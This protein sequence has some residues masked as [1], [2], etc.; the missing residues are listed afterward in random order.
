MALKTSEQIK[1][2]IATIG[3]ASAKLKANVQECAV[4]TIGHAR[5]H[6][7]YTLMQRLLD[8]LSGAVRKASLVA[9]FEKH[10]PVKWESKTEKLEF[11]KRVD[12][13]EWSEEVQEILMLSPW[14]EA[15][16]ETIKSIY[17]PVSMFESILKTSLAK[18]KKHEKINNEWAVIILE[19]AME[20][21]KEEERKQRIFRS[22]GDGL[23]VEEKGEEDGTQ[24]IEEP[25]LKVA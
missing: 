15:K 2:D 12:L 18:M 24:V 3:K 13:P 16:K 6:G 22:M 23:P 9:F 1:N 7:D 8:N 20:E 21:I 11:L 25:S 4:Q 5:L 19:K 10:G 17:D 14:D